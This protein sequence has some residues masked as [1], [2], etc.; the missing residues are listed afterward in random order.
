MRLLVLGATGGIGQ[1]LLDLS[2][3]A[4]HEVTAFARSPQKITIKHSNLKIVAGNL[5]NED[6]LSRVLH[7]QD[8]VLSAFGPM[9][10]KKS[11]TRGDFGRILASAMRKSGVRRVQLVSS[12]FLFPKVSLLGVVLRST[13]MRKVVP[14]MAEME[15]GIAKDFLDWTILRPPRLTNGE[16]TRRF[17]VADGQLPANGANISRADVAAFMVQEAEKPEHVQQIVGLSY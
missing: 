2:L 3:A 6:E 5:L 17:R 8:A 11:T 15:R 14:D 13:I 1:H 7:G 4:G 12:A 10:I 16:L 9:S